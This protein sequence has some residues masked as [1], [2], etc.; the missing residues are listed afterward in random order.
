M[1]GINIEHHRYCGSH[2]QKA[3]IELASLRQKHI[4]LPN[5]R[6]ATDEVERSANMNGWIHVRI[7]QHLRNHRRGCGLTMRTTNPNGGL[8][9]FHQLT[10]QGRTFDVWQAQTFHFHALWIVGSNRDGVHHQIRPVDVAGLMS[11][12]HGNVLI[13]SQMFGGIG[14]QAIG[15]REHVSLFLKHLRKSA[16]ARSTNANHM[17]MLTDKIANMWGIHRIHLLYFFHVIAVL[18]RHGIA[19]IRCMHGF[20][21]VWRTF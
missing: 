17:D 5:A 3:R 11:D 13:V 8:K 18:T 21:Q 15:S 1:I 12:G 19:I 10:E 7:H 9:P 16:H 20:N 6:T 14:F 2:V 4:A